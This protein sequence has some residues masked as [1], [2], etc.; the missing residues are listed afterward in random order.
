[1]NSQILLA[2]KEQVEKWY[3]GIQTIFQHVQK[4]NKWTKEEAWDK[5]ENELV[6][7]IDEGEFV[8]DDLEW[9]KDLLLNGKKPSIEEAL[10]VSKRYPDTTPL[11]DSLAKLF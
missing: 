3:L 10:R 2:N 5:L 9:V 1:M 4:C 11:I 6:N 7:G 8:P